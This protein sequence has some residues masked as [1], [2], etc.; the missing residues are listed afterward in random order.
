MRL[1]RNEKKEVL[2]YFFFSKNTRSFSPPFLLSPHMVINIHEQGLDCVVAH[3]IKCLDTDAHRGFQSNPERVFKVILGLFRNYGLEH[4][5]SENLEV[6]PVTLLL[7]FLISISYT[8][9][10]AYVCVCV[11]PSFSGKLFYTFRY[12]KYYLLCDV[13]RGRFNRDRSRRK[14][15]HRNTRGIFHPFFLLLLRCFLPLRGP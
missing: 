1:T 6:R 15:Q 12:L 10:V 11:Y 2:L 9:R 7:L 5:Y 8:L 4:I 14:A 13:V 3:L